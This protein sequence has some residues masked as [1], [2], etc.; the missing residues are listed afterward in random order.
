MEIGGGVQA[1][2]RF[3]LTN[4]IGCNVGITDGRIYELT[5]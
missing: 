2:F 5:H 1:I 4:L 3:Y